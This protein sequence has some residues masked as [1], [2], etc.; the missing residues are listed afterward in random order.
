MHGDFAYPLAEVETLREIRSGALDWKT[1]VGPMLDSLLLQV[2]ALSQSSPLPERADRA[3]GELFLLE[4]MRGHVSASD[5]C[6]G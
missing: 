2:D 3:W 4:V 6:V 1:R 5:L